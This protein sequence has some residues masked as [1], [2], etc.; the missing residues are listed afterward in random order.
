VGDETRSFVRGQLS[1]GSILWIAWCALW[2]ATWLVLGV[3]IWPLL[4]MVPV[5]LFA[6]ALGL[7]RRR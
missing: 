1:L 3:F 6:I 2:A 5:S 4:V 7:P